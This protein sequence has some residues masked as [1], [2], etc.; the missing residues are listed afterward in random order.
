[1]ETQNTGRPS[2]RHANAPCDPQRDQSSIGDTQT[3]K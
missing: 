1:M 3:K 2:S